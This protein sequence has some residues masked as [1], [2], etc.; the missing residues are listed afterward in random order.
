MGLATLATLA[1][2]ARLADLCTV[3]VLSGAHGRT[4]F[5]DTRQSTGVSG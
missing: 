1:I 5:C 2:A 3:F 4:G